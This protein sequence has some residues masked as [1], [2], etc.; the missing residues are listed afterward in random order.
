MCLVYIEYTLLKSQQ[1]NIEREIILRL[2]NK[3]INWSLYSEYLF[4]IVFNNLIVFNITYK[5]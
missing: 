1:S 5:S 3:G 2:Y 4:F